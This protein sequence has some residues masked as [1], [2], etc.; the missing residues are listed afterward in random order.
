LQRE[1]ALS[2]TEAEYNALSESLRE[3]I[4]MMQ[5][6]E[7][8]KDE[9][10]W[11][12]NEKVPTVHCKVFEDNSG[13]LDMARLPKMRPRTKHICVRMH[14]FREHVRTG[15]VTIHKVPSRLQLADIATKPQP[16]ELFESQR[17]SLMQWESEF[18]TREENENQAR[19][20]L[21]ACDIVY[22]V[23]RLTKLEGQPALNPASLQKRNCEMPLYTKYVRGDQN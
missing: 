13:A 5:L 15:K 9:L 12:I 7:E 20:H 22:E 1:V 16:R 19:E 4:N 14:H 10:K 6:F 18:R 17:E 11:A 3:V 23:S 21:R 8:T 2:T